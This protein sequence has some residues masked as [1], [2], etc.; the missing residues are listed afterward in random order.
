MTDVVEPRSFLARGI[1]RVTESAVGPYQTATVRIGI[2]GAWLLFLLV[3]WPNRHV[4]YG[5][6]GP[7]SW[8]MAVTKVDANGAFTALVWWDSPVWFELVYLFAIAT[9]AMLLLGWRTR[10]ASVLFMITLLSLQNRNTIMSDGGDNV[11][12][13][14]AIYLVGTQCGRSWSLDARRDSEAGLDPVGVV[15]WCVLGVAFAVVASLGLLGWGW[16]LVFGVLWVAHGVWWGVRR[17]ARGEPREVCRMSANLVHAGAV[18]VIIGQLCVLYASAGWYKIQGTR[19][20]DGTAAYFPMHVDA[21]TPWPWL[22]DLLSSNALPVL[23]MTYGT[24]LVQVAFPF[25]LFN[26]KLK[27]VLLACL[28]AEHAGIALLLGLPFFSAA[29]IA[30]DLIFLPTGFL[31]AVDRKVGDLRLRLMLRLRPRLRQP[32]ESTAPAARVL[33][34]GSA[35]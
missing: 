8:D 10:T 20:Q 14:M 26:R 28:I 1:A 23:M 22:S 4:L 2:S 25:S 27:N 24:V 30:A 32:R 18:A 11:F 13:L 35:S 31:L 9:A 5:P 7:N 15:L 6:E 21:F 33:P 29:I 17:Y 12:H 3:E 19:W 16:A 34:S